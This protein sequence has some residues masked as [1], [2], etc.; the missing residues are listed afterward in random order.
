[1]SSR[2]EWSGTGAM[3][4][5]I[6]SYEDKVKSAIKAVANYWKAVFERYAK[7]EAV[8]TDRTANA[9]QSLHAWVEETK[10]ST[11]HLYLSHGMEYGR[12]LEGAHAGK[13]SI[14]WPTIEAHL[15]Q[16]AKMLK[17]IFG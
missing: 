6:L 10:D 15:T 8:W 2:M 3:R 4:Q 1:M 5:K 7:E 17:G 14:I 11:V 12:F 9:R 16:I 13:F